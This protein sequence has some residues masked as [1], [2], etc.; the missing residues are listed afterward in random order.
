MSHPPHL[1]PTQSS[2]FIPFCA[3]KT[4]LAISENELSLSEMAFPICSSFLPTILDGQL[5]YR[6]TLNKTSAQGRKNE[7]MLLLD[8]NEDLSINTPT[9]ESTEFSEKTLNFDED[10]ERSQFELAK[11]HINTLSPY[12]GFGGGTYTM[13]VVKKMSAKSDFLKMPLNE[14]ECS[15]ETLEE[16]KTR[17]LLEECNCVPWEVPGYEVGS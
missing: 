14:R 4:D 2:A 15:I 1:S 16:C 3:Y 6:L 12:I 5:C 17:K 10:S 11:V 9:K 7:L 13:T 8:Y